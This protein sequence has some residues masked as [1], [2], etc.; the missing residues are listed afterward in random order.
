MG[1]AGGWVRQP[2]VPKSPL[3]LS[4]HIACNMQLDL[5]GKQSLLEQE[6]VASRLRAELDIL[7]R[8]SAEMRQQMVWQMVGS[9]QQAVGALSPNHLTQGRRKE[10]TRR[11]S[12]VH[13]S[14]FSICATAT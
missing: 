11:L 14:Q 9:L 8:D 5:P 10:L 12:P 4:Y 1:M 2:R 6:S 13:K 3:A 7:S